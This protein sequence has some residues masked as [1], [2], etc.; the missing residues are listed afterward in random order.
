[1]TSI[2]TPVPDARKTIL[3]EIP[4]SLRLETE[5]DN[6]PAGVLRMRWLVLAVSLVGVA[7]AAI[8][9]R[10]RARIRRPEVGA[11][12]DEWIAQHR[13]DHQFPSLH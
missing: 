10:S 6:K 12:S 13:A 5:W 9:A 7:V 1:V 4:L 2:A 11:V 3:D 8:T